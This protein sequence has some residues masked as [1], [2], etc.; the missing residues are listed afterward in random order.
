[1][2]THNTR[3]KD[4]D[5]E[6]ALR[7]LLQAIEATENLHSMTDLNCTKEQFEESLKEQIQITVGSK[8]VAF[9]FGGPQIEGLLKFV[10]QIAAENLHDI[11]I[12][13]KY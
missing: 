1:M 2:S 9:M 7:E 10:E 6:E 8:T 13:P 11:E 5:E 12:E 4:Y 3:L